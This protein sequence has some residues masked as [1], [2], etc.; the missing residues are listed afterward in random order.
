MNV[1]Y[2]DNHVLV[3]LKPAGVPSQAD[4]SGDLDLL[5][6]AKYYIKQ[7]FNKPGEVFLGLVHR[8]DRPA[9]GLMVFARTSKAASR[10]VSQFKNRLVQK[11]Y[12]AKVHGHPPDQA[13]WQDYL[14]KKDRSVHVVGADQGGQMAALKFESLSREAGTELVKVEL[15]TGRPHQIRVQF[16]SRGFPLVGDVRYGSNIK[17]GNFL[18][19]HA[20]ALAFAHPT[21]PKTLLFQTPDLP[22]WV[23]D[24]TAVR[25]W[26]NRQVSEFHGHQ[27]N[28]DPIWIKQN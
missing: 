4:E 20:M 22:N 7:K 12:L 6:Q 27:L 1:L 13:R 3:V 18:C 5:N 8:L 16:A 15:E 24:P 25:T 23:E 10:L 28:S 26:L 14:L 19:L 21:Q 9:S 11:H 2:C 17:L